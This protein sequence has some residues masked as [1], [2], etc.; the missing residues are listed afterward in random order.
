[1]KQINLKELHSM[2]CENNLLLYECVTI[3]QDSGVCKSHKHHIFEL[4]LGIIIPKHLI[5]KTDD[6]GVIKIVTVDIHYD[7]ADNDLYTGKIL[8]LFLHRQSAKTRIPPLSV[9]NGVGAPTHD[10][11]DILTLY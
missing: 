3:D 7:Y 8:R 2:F 4:L 10:K 1:M 6:D 11:D 5:I 9:S